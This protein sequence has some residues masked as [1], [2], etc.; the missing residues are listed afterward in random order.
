MYLRGYY[1]FFIMHK[2]GKS[3]NS[4]S[5]IEKSRFCSVCFA[6]I[7]VC[8]F[9]CAASVACLFVFAL[10]N[11]TKGV[12]KR[13]LHQCI[14][15]CCDANVWVAADARQPL[16]CITIILRRKKEKISK[17]VLTNRKGYDIICKYLLERPSRRC[18]CS[19]MVEFQPSKLAAWVRFPSLAP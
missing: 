15:S 2:I 7:G 4:K 1:T 18:E 16:F 17:K 9:R 6:T 8:V 10:R 14:A 12:R 19:S 13:K 3:T 11:R 5:I